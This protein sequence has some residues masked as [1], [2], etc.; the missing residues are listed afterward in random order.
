MKAS[1]PLIY[2]DWNVVISLADGGLP[3][4]LDI[5]VTAR[6]EHAI[7]IPFS[8]TH[9]QEA[10]NIADK[11]SAHHELVESRLQFLSELSNNTYLYNAADVHSP[12]LRIEHPTTV[13]S[14]INEVS[15]AKPIM[16]D[17]V[18]MFGF[19]AMKQ[20]RK[21]LELE[22]KELNNIKPPNVIDQLDKIV[23]EKTK[24]KY[25]HS[26]S[27]FGVKRLLETSLKYY[28]DSKNLGLESR[29][30]AVFSSLNFLGFWPDKEKRTNLVAAFNDAL[31]AAT[32]SYCDYFVTEDRSLRVKTMAAYEFFEVAT[33]VG[34]TSEAMSFIKQLRT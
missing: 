6:K 20:F 33:N 31:H 11:P 5:L 29:M 15:W 26:G 23:E 2:L 21:E 8:A 34:H 12:E 17:F 28:P 3:L 27:G 4:F 7:I 30:A 10:N 14:T 13:R 18:N 1:S 19:D 24:N 22:P 32:A 25:P 9:V 16:H